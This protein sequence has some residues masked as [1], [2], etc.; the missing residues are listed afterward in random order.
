MSNVHEWRN[1]RWKHL[2]AIFLHKNQEKKNKNKKQREEG[3][4]YDETIASKY[5]IK[6]NKKQKLFI[7]ICSLT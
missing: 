1:C 4:T 5:K 2:S 3:T 6:R 7:R